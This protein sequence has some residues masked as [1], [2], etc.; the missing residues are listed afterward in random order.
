MAERKV[1]GVFILQRRFAYI[2]HE[3]AKNLKKEG[4]VHQF[5]A[6]VQLRDSYRFLRD[7]KDITYTD[8]LLDEEIQKLY[9]NEPLDTQYLKELEEK[10]GNTLWKYIYVDR[11]ISKHQLVREYPYDK[12]P[13]A[14]EELLR[15]VQVYAKQ[16][17]AFLDKERPDFVYGFLFAG[18][19]TLLL[20]DI[21]KVKGIPIL[22]TIVPATRDLVT[23]SESYKRLT[24]VEKKFRENL[25]KQPQDVEGYKEAK[26][27]L[28]EFRNKP[29]VYSQVVVAREPSKRKEQ[30]SFLRPRKLLWTVYYN[31]FH[32]FFNWWKDRDRRSDYTTVNPFL[33]LWDRSKRKLRNLRGFRGLYDPFDI[34][35]RY[36]FYALQY[37]PEATLLVLAPFELDQKTVIARLARSLPADMYLYVKEHPGMVPFRPRSFYN[38][39]KK[40]PNV[41]LIDPAVSSFELIR[42]SQ[43]V[44]TITGT[45]GWEAVIFNKPA[46]T[47]GHV[48][49]N[50][51]SFVGKSRT[52]EALPDLVRKQLNVRTDER[53]LL[54]FLSALFQ[55]SASL[56]L[57]Y[58]WEV[59]TDEEKRREGFKKFAKVIGEK[60]QLVTKS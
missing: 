58:L 30:F 20:H 23:I 6:Y 13:Y 24:F 16:I 1:K 55:D 17:E 60:I 25:A 14:R 27:F 21:A 19:G 31:M 46:I 50:A 29:S 51:L 34:N 48:F 38:D 54:A 45:P 52:P 5:C 40:I 36:A 57:M 32:I 47:F 49:Y 7:Q 56:D 15:L 4:I 12:S 37:E 8:L 22:T 28:E 10:F 41:R 35:P 9:R 2:G 3:I 59:E 18:L 53:E 26:Q 11:V 42:H 39:L 33:H 43:L 44:A